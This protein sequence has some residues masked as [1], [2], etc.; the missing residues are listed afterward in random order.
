[1]KKSIVAYTNNAM[2]MPTAKLND[3]A[4]TIQNVSSVVTII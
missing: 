1:M 2:I 3:F 4:V